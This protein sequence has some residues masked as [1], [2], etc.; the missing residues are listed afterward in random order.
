[1][2]CTNVTWM[3]SDESFRSNETCNGRVCIAVWL[4][5][6]VFVCACTCVRAVC[7]FASENTHPP[8]RIFR[9]RGLMFE[10]ASDERV[11]S[12]IYVALVL[13]EFVRLRVLGVSLRL[14]AHMRRCTLRMNIC[15]SSSAICLWSAFVCAHACMRSLVCICDCA[16][17]RAN[18][19]ARCAR[20]LAKA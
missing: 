1:M 19:C 15:L 20:P 5:L 17:E 4:C 18:S 11:S 12:H 2:K 9:Y 16:R 7:K 13:C 6:C 14:S 8:D 3:I 10:N